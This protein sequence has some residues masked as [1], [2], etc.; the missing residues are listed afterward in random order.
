VT[1]Q[2]DSKRACLI[3]D[4]ND[5]LRGMVRAILLGAGWR[6]AEAVNGDQ[7][8][9][10][11]TEDGFCVVLLDIL[12]PAKDGLEVLLELEKRPEAA[13]PRIVAMSG[14][15]SKVT[16]S[17]ALQLAEGLGA[18]KILHKPFS[19]DELREAME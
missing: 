11:I 17:L 15:G 12:M 5:E 3:V 19:L 4:D 10:Q 18:R 6:V 9:R 14:G 7:A 16:G 2:N 1:H 8:L 13:R